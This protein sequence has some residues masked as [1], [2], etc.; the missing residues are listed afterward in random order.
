VTF[1]IYNCGKILFRDGVPAMSLDCCC[2]Y[3]VCCGDCFF[4]VSPV[5]SEPDPFVDIGGPTRIE[6]LRLVLSWPDP[7]YPCSDGETF[8][9]E[10]IQEQVGPSQ[11]LVNA[12]GFPCFSGGDDTTILVK[13]SRCT[14]N[15]FYFPVEGSVVCPEDDLP[16]A[17]I[18]ITIRY[19]GNGNW[20]FSG[21]GALGL[22]TTGGC[23]GTISHTFTLDVFP[24]TT[25]TIT[26]DVIREFPPGKSAA[27][28]ECPSP[29]VQDALGLGGIG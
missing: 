6:N 29:G 7:G 4:P 19:A 14:F 12:V 1:P 8:L 24:F 28:Y 16:T 10:Y 13:Y 18:P 25:Q 23:D 11:H 26:W 21:P 9:T 27:D 22:R 17:P 20:D 3:Y 5:I 15:V 2:D